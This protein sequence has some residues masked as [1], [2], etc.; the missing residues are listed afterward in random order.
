MPQLPHPTSEITWSALYTVSQ[1][2]AWDSAPVAHSGNSPKNDSFLTLLPFLSSF[3]RLYQ[4]FLH[5]SNHPSPCFRVCFWGNKIKISF[6][7]LLYNLPLQGRSIGVF[8][9]VHIYICTKEKVEN[10]YQGGWEPKTLNPGSSELGVCSW[11]R[12]TFRSFV[13]SSKIR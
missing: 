11:P 8:C 13:S 1:S 3:P 10:K 6:T 9:T 4:C 2:L 7:I 12:Y 5:L